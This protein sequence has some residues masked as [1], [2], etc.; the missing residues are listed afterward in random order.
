MPAASAPE[1]TTTHVA[2]CAEARIGC[3]GQ[4]ASPIPKAMPMGKTPK[5]CG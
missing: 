5:S 2:V 1:K 4:N 3:I